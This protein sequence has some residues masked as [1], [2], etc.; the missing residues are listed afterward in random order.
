MRGKAVSIAVVTNFFFN[1][2]MAF[3]F[4]VELETIGSAGTFYL[5]GA[6]LV[7]GILYIYRYVP[8]TKG[9]TLEEIEEYFLKISLG[10]GARRGEGAN[11]EIQP[12][13][14]SSLHGGGG[15]GDSGSKLAPL[16]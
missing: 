13:T 14:T 10:Q 16:I 6:I 2:V 15:G 5:Y 8:E 1:A 9:F 7:C 12:L 3:L 11:E 4:P